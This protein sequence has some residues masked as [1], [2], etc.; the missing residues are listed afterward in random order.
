MYNKMKDMN[1]EKR[2]GYSMIIY[3]KNAENPNKM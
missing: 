1:I 3:K 2:Y